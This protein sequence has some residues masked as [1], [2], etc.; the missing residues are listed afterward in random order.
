MMRR[1]VKYELKNK[2]PVLS[3]I[4]CSFVSMFTVNEL[5]IENDRINKLYF[6]KKE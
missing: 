3:F 1:F 5:I 6:H 4:G 2:Q